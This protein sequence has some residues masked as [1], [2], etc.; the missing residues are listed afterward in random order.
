[1]YKCRKPDPQLKGGRNSF[2][3]YLSIKSSIPSISE[4]R[5]LINSRDVDKVPIPNPPENLTTFKAFADLLYFEGIPFPEKFFSRRWN[6]SQKEVS[7]RLKLF[8]YQ[9]VIRLENDSYK[10]LVSIKEV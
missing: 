3:V 4:L 5:K 10:V 8:Q 1:M 9:G 7:D 6:L 2:P